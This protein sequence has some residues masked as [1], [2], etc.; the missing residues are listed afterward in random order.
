MYIYQ[1]VPLFAYV[2]IPAAVIEIGSTAG[3]YGQDYYVSSPVSAENGDYF[4]TDISRIQLDNLANGF[5]HPALTL[6]H[7][8]A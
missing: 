5:Q 7:W 2:K 1:S 3:G 8:N 6:K 4:G